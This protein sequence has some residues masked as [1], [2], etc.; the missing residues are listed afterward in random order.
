MDGGSERFM[1]GVKTVDL[2]T[3]SGQLRGCRYL[4]ERR[5]FA[6]AG[7]AYVL[8]ARHGTVGSFHREGANA[9]AQVGI[10]YV[11]IARHRGFLCPSV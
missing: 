10:A 9:P 1:G 11:L 7:I 3:E 4:R 2:E 8:I 5:T 6:Q